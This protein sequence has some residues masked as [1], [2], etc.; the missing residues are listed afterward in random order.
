MKR[1]LLLSL[2]SVIGLLLAAAYVF[3]RSITSGIP[4]GDT[5]ATQ[6]F[7]FQCCVIFIGSVYNTGAMGYRF[8]GS[9]QDFEEIKAYSRRHMFI[10]NAIGVALL[11]LGIVFE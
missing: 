1:I 7:I 5:F 11:V 2:G 4:K 10:L 6:A 8:I 9:P 3:F